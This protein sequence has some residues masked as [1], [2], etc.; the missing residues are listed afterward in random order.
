MNGRANRCV[1]QSAGVN[2]TEGMPLVPISSKTAKSKKVA[3]LVTREKTPGRSMIA[4]QYSTSSRPVTPKHSS[5]R[6]IKVTRN[7]SPVQTSKLSRSPVSSKNAP[8]KENKPTPT[9][10][11]TFDIG[12]NFSS[13]VRGKENNPDMA[14]DTDGEKLLDSLRE[15]CSRQFDPA[16]LTSHFLNIINNPSMKESSAFMPKDKCQRTKDGRHMMQLGEASIYYDDSV[17]D[18]I[19]NFGMRSRVSTIANAN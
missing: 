15:G 5:A 13:E 14:N 3:A 9:K 4:N 19:I 11:K 2:L 12:E 18:S 1:K 8:G 7:A 6:S 16:K 10:T 17:I